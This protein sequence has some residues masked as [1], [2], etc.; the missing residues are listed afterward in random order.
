MTAAAQTQIGGYAL[1]PAALRDA[2]MLGVTIQ[3]IGKALRNPIP[4]VPVP[5]TDG[6]CNTYGEIA[7]GRNIRMILHPLGSRIENITRA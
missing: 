4:V 2:G 1:T 6:R 5:R 7:N 3:E